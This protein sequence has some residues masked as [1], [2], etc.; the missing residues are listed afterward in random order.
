MSEISLPTPDLNPRLLSAQ[1]GKRVH[2]FGVQVDILLRS[3]DTDGSHAL[4]L[5]TASPGTGAPP[6]VHRGD[7]E[8]FHILEGELEVLQGEE[9]SR[10]GAGTSIYLPRG[11][12]HAFRNPGELPV[13]FLGIATPGGHERFFEAVDQLVTEGRFTPEAGAEVCRQFGMELL[14]PGRE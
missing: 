5:V 9:W 10:V 3:E 8:T 13:R 11:V 4:Y 1:D 2:V 6:H 14:A 7:D 12:A